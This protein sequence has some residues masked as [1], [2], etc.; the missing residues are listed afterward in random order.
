MRERTLRKTERAVRDGM[1]AIFSNEKIRKRRSELGNGHLMWL[2]T[3]GVPWTFARRMGRAWVNA[4]RE[5][6]IDLLLEEVMP[7]SL[8]MITGRENC[9]LIRKDFEELG[10]DPLEI[11]VGE[12]SDDSPWVQASYCLAAVSVIRS[13]R[14]GKP[15][16]SKDQMRELVTTESGVIHATY[17][18]F[19]A[20]LCGSQIFSIT[21]AL[22]EKLLLT[23]VGKV[24]AED[25]HVPFPAFV[26]QLPP[27]FAQL[28]DPQTGKHD[29]DTIIIVEGKEGGMRRLEAFF[30][31]REN[32]NSGAPGDD[33][34]LFENIF[35][36][37]GH[38]LEDIIN[39]MVQMESEYR[40]AD[41]S[42]LG[43]S[44]KE[45]IR[46][47]MRFACSIVLYISSHPE[48]RKKTINPEI[49][50]L[51]NKLRGVKGKKRKKLKAR[52]NQL[53]K[54][55]VPYLVGTYVTIS[56]ELSKVAKAI[57]RGDSTQPSVTSYVRG[58]H[59]MQ[60]HGPKMSL[61]KMI[62]VEPYWR[63]FGPVTQKTY[64][65]K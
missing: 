3:V 57:G 48:D 53:L 56:A 26:I 19:N 51:H 15:L 45:A 7:E 35:L 58:H 32:E 37:E 16:P 29:V 62:W 52:L 20:W 4:R 44:G 8:T 13:D 40:E 49:N 65:V 33:S 18:N 54:E 34:T 43:K 50:K 59:K 38:T 17:A 36:R 63:G 64:T 28:N 41:V 14:T 12:E 60:P 24:Q 11:P 6:D 42:V 10:I 23:D 55:P 25:L 31:A 61:R 39:G 21:E 27:N 47:L 30:M 22:A 1:R 2:E 46:Q 5:G 9:A